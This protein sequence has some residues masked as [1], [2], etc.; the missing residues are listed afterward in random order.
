MIARKK[1]CFINIVSISGLAADYGFSVYNAAKAAVVNLTKN[2]AINYGIYGIRANI[3]C[4]G[5]IST[6][7]LEEAF[8]KNINIDLRKQFNE[9]YPMGRIDTPQEVASVVI[10]LASDAASFINGAVPV[11]DGGPYLPYRKTEVLMTPAY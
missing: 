7:L 1:G 5:E 9:A 10:F 4:P 2:N 3:V 11:V 8:N 6:S